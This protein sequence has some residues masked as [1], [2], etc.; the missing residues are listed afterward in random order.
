[1]IMPFD[2]FG[3]DKYVY[4][5]E[6][7]CKKV[8]ELVLQDGATCIFLNTHGKNDNEVPQELRDFL[9]Y[10][11]DTTDQRAAASNSDR[12]KRI[13]DQV[14][15]VKLNEEAGVRYIFLKLQTC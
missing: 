2:L 5:F 4:T 13:H 1:M 7:K 11:E 14:R 6:P 3:Y 12:I 15:I 9:H 10:L 8:P